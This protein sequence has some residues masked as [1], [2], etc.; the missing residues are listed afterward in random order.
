MKYDF[1]NLSINQVNEKWFDSG[2]YKHDK[3]KTVRMCIDKFKVIGIGFVKLDQ[4]G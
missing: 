4:F 2:G 1:C 3:T